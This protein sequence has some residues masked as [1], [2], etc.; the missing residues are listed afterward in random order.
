MDHV[1]LLQIGMILF[2][3]SPWSSLLDTLKHSGF[4]FDT[5]SFEE[6]PR[7]LR[8]SEARGE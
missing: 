8:E 7:R 3:I 4:E 2:T 5:L 6:W 1:H